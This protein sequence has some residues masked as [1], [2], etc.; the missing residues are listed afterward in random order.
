LLIA[1]SEEAAERVVSAD[2]HM[3]EP[4][5][6]GD[7]FRQRTQGSGVRDA[8]MRT[9]GAGDLRWALRE[10]DPAVLFGLAYLGVTNV[11]ALRSTGRLRCQVRGL[12]GSV[13]SHPAGSREDPCSRWADRHD[14]APGSKTMRRGDVVR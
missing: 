7:R 6:V 2:V 5:R 11:I 8:P 10:D 1:R 14:S 9:I 13:V 12:L 3:G 4:V